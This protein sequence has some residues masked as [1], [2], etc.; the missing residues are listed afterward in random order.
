M[1]VTDVTPRWNSRLCH[2]TCCG[3]ALAGT[4][5]PSPLLMLMTPGWIVG[6]H[7]P[8]VSNSIGH[9][10]LS[11]WNLLS[12]ART[13][14][15]RLALLDIAQAWLALAEHADKNCPAPALVYE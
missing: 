3:A 15:L 11:V 13:L 10:P 14:K 4:N 2:L 5:P 1:N 6:C 7:L 8:A 12:K 9:T